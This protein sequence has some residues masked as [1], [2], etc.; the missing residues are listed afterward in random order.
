MGVIGYSLALVH[1][2]YWRVRDE[3]GIGVM[4]KR[5]QIINAIESTKN[6]PY[7]PNTPII[8]SCL[9]LFLCGLYN[10]CV[11][12]IEFLRKF[13]CMMKFLIKYYIEKELLNKTGLCKLGQK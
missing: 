13:L 3:A 10:I 12:F 4:L 8:F 9:S 7:L 1:A 11:S 5:K 2:K 6:R